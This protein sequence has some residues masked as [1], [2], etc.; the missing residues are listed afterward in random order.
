MVPGNVEAYG[1]GNNIKTGL[2]I[3]SVILVNRYV[4]CSCGFTEEW[5]DIDDIAKLKKN[6]IIKGNLT[7]IITHHREIFTLLV[8]F[9]KKYIDVITSIPLTPSRIVYDK[10]NT[11]YGK[12]FCTQDN[13]GIPHLPYLLM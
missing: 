9:C 11:G 8:A 2:T 7:V 10:K 5:I 3:F 6:T 1:V 13:N 12:L 4:C